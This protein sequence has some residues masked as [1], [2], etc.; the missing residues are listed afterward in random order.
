[1]EYQNTSVPPNLNFIFCIQSETHR[2]E[3]AYLIHWPLGD[4]AVAIA[5][6]S[7]PVILPSGEYKIGWGNG[8]LERSG[9]KPNLNTRSMTDYT[10]WC[11][12][13]AHELKHACQWRLYSNYNNIKILFK[14][15]HYSNYFTYLS[16]VEYNWNVIRIIHNAPWWKLLVTC[17]LQ[18][19]NSDFQ[20][21][22]K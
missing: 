10:I 9:K 22:L 20:H 11:Y 4:V 1:M 17:T 12:E 16:C 15:M 6:F 5:V 8:G 13:A 2:I 3:P 18:N 14:Q 21:K 19:G 7:I